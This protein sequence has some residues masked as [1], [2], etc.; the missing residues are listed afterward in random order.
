M[1][2]GEVEIYDKPLW[3]YRAGGLREVYRGGKNLMMPW[4]YHYKQAFTTDPNGANLP[5]VDFPWTFIQ[6][7]PLT[8]RFI[9]PLSEGDKQ[10][11]APS[12]DSHGWY[13]F[14]CANKA[15]ADRYHC[16]HPD[17]SQPPHPAKKPTANEDAQRLADQLRSK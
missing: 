6:E 11:I 4:Q 1:W 3:L 10:R 16:D 9:H 15:S 7:F 8:L 5:P 13:V 2:Y 14:D 12:L 17:L